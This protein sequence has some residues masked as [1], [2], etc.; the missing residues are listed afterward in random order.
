[1]YNGNPDWALPAIG[2]WYRFR[3]SFDRALAR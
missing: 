2:A 3:D 1:M